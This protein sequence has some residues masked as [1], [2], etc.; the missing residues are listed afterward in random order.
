M[1]RPIK[2]EWYQQHIKIK[3]RKKIIRV[4]NET[5]RKKNE[6]NQPTQH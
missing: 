4:V 1:I 6:K 5:K 2:I 3:T